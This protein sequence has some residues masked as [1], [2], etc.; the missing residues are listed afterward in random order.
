VTRAIVRTGVVDVPDVASI[1]EQRR[2]ARIDAAAAH[3]FWHIRRYVIGE[4]IPN[5]SDG[6]AKRLAAA[7]VVELVTS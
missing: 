6:E 4:T 3:T 5:L 7:G 1:S 2:L